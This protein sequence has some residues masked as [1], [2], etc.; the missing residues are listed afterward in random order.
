M[1]QHWTQSTEFNLEMAKDNPKVTHGFD[2]G[3]HI[4]SNVS[5]LSSKIRYKHCIV[6]V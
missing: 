2:F 1:M 6:C 4:G 5:M 3:S